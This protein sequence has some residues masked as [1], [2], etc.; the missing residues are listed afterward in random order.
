MDGGVGENHAVELFAVGERPTER[1]WPAPIMSHGHDASSDPERLG[2]R[3]CVGNPVSE[4]ARRSGAFG[5]PHVEMVHCDDTQLGERDEN[6]A[7]QIRPRWVPVKAQ[8]RQRLG[9][10]VGH[11]V[12]YV[13]R[14][15]AVMAGDGYEARPRA[16]HPGETRR[17]KPGRIHR[18]VSPPSIRE[19]TTGR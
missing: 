15:L 11:R 18:H 1:D 5:E 17:R 3:G 6:M 10:C 4:T 7:P 16:V 2:Q 19:W 9:A 13:K 8:E 14:P 12:E